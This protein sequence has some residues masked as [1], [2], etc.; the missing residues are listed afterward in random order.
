MLR[1][2]FEISSTLRARAPIETNHGKQQQQNKYKM[3]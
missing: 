3:K 2:D 1:L